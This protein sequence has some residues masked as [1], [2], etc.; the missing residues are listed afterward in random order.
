MGDLTETLAKR[1]RRMREERGWTQEELAHRVGVS[2]RYIGEIERHHASPTV[3]VL[4]S[5]AAAFEVEPGELLRSLGDAIR[6]SI[7]RAA[8]RAT[9]CSRRTSASGR[10]QSA[11]GTAPFG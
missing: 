9:R 2:A 5:I 4:G 8:P 1:T 10:R 11:S 7:E 3:N 6:N